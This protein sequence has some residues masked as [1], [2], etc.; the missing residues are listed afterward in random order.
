MNKTRSLLLDFILYFMARTLGCVLQALSPGLALRVVHA[1]ANLG[2]HV[3]KRHRQVALDNLAHAFPQT[4]QDERKHL[5][6][7]VYRHFGMLLLEMLLIL[8][9]LSP[10]NWRR[11]I[12]LP[13]D[14]EAK[15]QTAFSSGRPV[16]I[17]TAHFG[18][19]ELSAHCLSLFG[20]KAHLVARPLD[21]P[22][23]DALVQRFREWRGHKVLGKSGSLF[24]MHGV[25]AKGGVLC[26]LA[27]QDAGPDG[28][29]VDF[30]GRPASTHKAIA[31]LALWSRALILVMGLENTGGFLQY[32]LRLTDVIQPEEYAGKA[33]AAVAIT[34]RITHGVERLVRHDP[35]Q[36][37]WL[38]RRWKHQPGDK[39][40]KQAA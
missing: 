2:Y 4:S 31:A 17:V 19:W 37:L 26:T 30:F 25:L 22:F 5:V 27:D 12:T 18:N 32:T 40:G 23:V 14:V 3:D 29:F 35:G 8:R 28:L 34:Q 6:R 16:L 10:H 13:A 39:K 21:N 20:V 7:K 9:K 24:A 36:Y 38:H 33:R 11:Q 1:L 15:L